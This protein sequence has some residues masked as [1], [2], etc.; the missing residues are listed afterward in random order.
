MTKLKKASATPLNER[1]DNLRARLGGSKA[2]ALLI[3]NPRD[4]RYLTGFVGD[5]S[6]AV[7]PLNGKG[8]PRPVILS[9]FRFQEQIQRE[10]PQAKAVMRKKGLVEEL[11]KL[12]AK[13]K[14]KRIALQPSYVNLAL[15][16]RLVKEL[17][18]KRLVEVEDDLLKQRA[19]KSE[20]EVR[21]IRRALKIHQQALRET[22]RFMKPGQTEVE[23]AA[24]F[25]YRIRTLGADGTSFPTIVAADANASLPHA[26]P[27]PAKLKRGGIVL[28][29]CGARWGGYCSDLTRV[30]AFGTMPRKMR[31]VYQVVLDAQLKAIDAIK[32]GASL[33]DIDAIA[34]KHIQKHGYGKRFGHSLGH[35]IGLDIHELPTLSQR[36][37]GVL[38]PGHVVT[39]EPGVYLPG[40]GG[41]RIEDDVLVTPRGHEVL[42]DLPKDLSSAII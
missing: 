32:P 37:E 12:S 41:V 6:W 34:R 40:V 39:V 11:Q 27:G 36:S 9:D 7:I 3:T 38:E 1:I 19:V 5:D 2:D 13:A 42:S 29:D 33:K 15:R 4:I 22:I 18:A 25:E 14:L 16:K 10:A 35:G 23:V 28:I 30:Y 26:I 24:Y 31:E 21:A 8:R 20:G 17:G